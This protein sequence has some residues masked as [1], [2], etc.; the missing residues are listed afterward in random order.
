MQTRNVTYLYN[1]W[2]HGKCGFVN[3]LLED[4]GTMDSYMDNIHNI[5]KI[6][7]NEFDFNYW[8]I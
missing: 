8:L 4:S 3:E 6:N 2:S 7:W 5:R 1:V